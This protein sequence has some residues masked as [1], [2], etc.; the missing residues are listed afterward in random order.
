MHILICI[1]IHIYYIKNAQPC[2]TH[3]LQLGPG[4]IFGF[5]STPRCCLG[6]DS[7]IHRGRGYYLLYVL[8]V[9]LSYMHKR[10][11][12]ILSGGG[13]TND[14]S[15]S[16]TT[17]EGLCKFFFTSQIGVFGYVHFLFYT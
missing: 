8:K 4:L 2:S 11:F 13:G 7:G 15:L 17:K 1:Y 6:S 9:F 14:L 12:S 16:G 5:L 3:R 10:Q